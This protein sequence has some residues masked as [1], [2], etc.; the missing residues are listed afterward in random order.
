MKKI[1]LSEQFT[2]SDLLNNA[3]SDL[4]AG[5]LF[6]REHGSGNNTIKL[7]AVQIRNNQLYIHYRSY[8]T[9]A[10]DTTRIG[11]NGS[12]MRTEWYDTL[13]QFDKVDENLGDSE[14]F[15]QFNPAEQAAAVSDFL[16]KG[17]CRVWDNCGAYYYQGHW[18]A[19][20]AIDATIFDFPGPKG[21]GEWQDRHK[22]GL[23]TPGITICKHIAA[24][25]PKM[26]KR[27]T[28]AIAKEVAKLSF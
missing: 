1:R 25:I 10:T 17:L 9:Y 11:T 2:V 20:D 27:D 18:E 5:F 28:R 8:P 26:L 13:F 19:M 16:S 22:P 15:N 3:V 21:T 6:D 7:H 24:C 12:E 23:T 14:T 4:T